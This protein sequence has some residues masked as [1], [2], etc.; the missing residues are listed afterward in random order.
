MNNEDGYML[1]V[2][3]EQA[4]DVPIVSSGSYYDM[5]DHKMLM[6]NLFLSLVLPKEVINGKS[7]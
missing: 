4:R 7:G 1:N 2:L 6:D 5:P 3:A